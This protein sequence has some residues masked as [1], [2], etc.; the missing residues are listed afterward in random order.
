MQVF[1]Y[2]TIAISGMR[3]LA[4]IPWNRR[5]RFIL[6]AAFG[7]GLLDIVT[8]KWFSQ[9]LAY[10]GPNVHLMGFLEG[11]NLMVET[12]F[13]LSMLVA[14]I[15]NTIMPRDKGQQAILAPLDRP[16]SSSEQESG[17]EKRDH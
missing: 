1:L 8:P 11:V 6:S 5:N 13:I 12:P 7:L 14:L 9:V 15:L 17:S 2:S 16:S 4:T 10:S 3:I